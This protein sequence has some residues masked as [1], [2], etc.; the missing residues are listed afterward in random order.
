MRSKVIIF[1]IIA[2]LGGTS[3]IAM[4]EP[5]D[6][7]ERKFERIVEL[8]GFSKDQIFDATRIWIA[9]NFKSA[10]AVIEYE[11]KEAGTII[12]NGIIPYPASGG[13]LKQVTFANWKVPF[14]MKVDI[15]DQRFRLTFSNIELDTPGSPQFGL[16]PSRSPV[17]RK[18]DLDRI[19]PELLKFGDQI[20]AAIRAGKL[21]SDW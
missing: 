14:T 20:S 5:V 1:F 13:P 8:P 21:K 18:V 9:E 3:L 12:G 19:R 10:K 15:K 17:R 16:P 6:E 7:S 2:A 11:N 4:A